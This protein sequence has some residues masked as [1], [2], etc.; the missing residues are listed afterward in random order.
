M[1]RILVVDD[2]E[3]VR[4]LLKEFLEKKGHEVA[5]AKDGTE[6]LEKIK[7]GPEIILLDLMMPGINGMD[8]Y[9]KVI[10]AKPGNKLE[11]ASRIDGAKI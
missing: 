7:E 1:A 9:G 8:V 6:A 2:E 10:L 4:K 3:I 5:I 11:F